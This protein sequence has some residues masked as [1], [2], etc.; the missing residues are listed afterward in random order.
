[1]LIKQERAV[2]RIGGSGKWP[3][4]I[5][6]LVCEFF[7]DGTPPTAVCKDITTAMGTMGKEAGT[8]PSVNFIQQYRVVVQNLNEMLAA[9]TL[10]KAKKW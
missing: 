7:V 3:L 4:K 5:I 10:G 6:L 9:F 2:G 1:M 8:P